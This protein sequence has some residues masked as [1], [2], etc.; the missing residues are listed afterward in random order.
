ML[1]IY[2]SLLYN[3]LE[4]CFDYDLF[5]VRKIIWANFNQNKNHSIISKGEQ[6]I[7]MKRLLSIFLA[8]AMILS[9]AACTSAPIVDNDTNDGTNPNTPAQS[10]S[11]DR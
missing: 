5:C 9:L 4:K 1:A 11:S 10:T 2:T 3:I 7:T 8:V 6:S